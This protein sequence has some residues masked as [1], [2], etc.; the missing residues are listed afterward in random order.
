MNFY[1]KLHKILNE[2]DTQQ[3]STSDALTDIIN[4][5]EEYDAVPERP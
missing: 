2:V 5:L 4:L 3:T 1:E